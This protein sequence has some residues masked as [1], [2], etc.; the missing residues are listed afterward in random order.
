[1]KIK[2]VKRGL[3]F[4]CIVVLTMSILLGCQNTLDLKFNMKKGDKYKVVITSAQKI[5][6]EMSGQKI[7][8]DQTLKTSYLYD[9]TDV[10][11]DGTAT[12]NI[13]FDTFSIKMVN[14]N[15]TYEFDSTK[16][17]DEKDAQGL[18]YRA[19][20]GQSFTLKISKDGKVQEITGVDKLFTN[21]ID[22]LQISDQKAK[23]TLV[24]TLKQS[25][26]DEALKQNLGSM[27]EMYP[28]NKKIKVGD[29]WENKQTI[30][31]GYPMTINSKWTLKANEGDILTMD[32]DSSIDADNSSKPMDLMGLKVK[33]AL[34]GTQKGTMKLTKS[35]GFIQNGEV[36]Q[37]ITGSM[38]IEANDAFPSGIS[39]PMTIEGKTTYE[40]T[41]Q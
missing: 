10:A 28:E 31:A 1:M 19:L 20:V 16:T 32:V 25:F 15:Q 12:V 34:K 4:L 27:T 30:T 38:N 3:S 9:V 11:S 7:N 8:I 18:A 26:G 40:V 37:N 13:K 36:D 24:E 41:K 29:S 2:G 6:E 17:N 33:Y 14:G 21:I 22:K 39:V 23:D 5:A 35:N